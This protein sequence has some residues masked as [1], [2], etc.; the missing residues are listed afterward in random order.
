VHEENDAALDDKLGLI[1]IVWYASRIL[2]ER[3]AAAARD[4]RR[5]SATFPCPIRRVRV[6]SHGRAGQAGPAQR[7]AGAAGPARST[8][9]RDPLP[10]AALWPRRAAAWLQMPR[11][12]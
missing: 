6:P 5:A 9:G 11:P 2:A 7:G 1:E 4:D 10:A 12:A 8:R 3:I